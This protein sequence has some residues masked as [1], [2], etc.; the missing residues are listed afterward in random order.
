MDWEAALLRRVLLAM[1]ESIA[2][3]SDAT[4]DFLRPATVAMVWSGTGTGAGLA[5]GGGGMRVGYC[6]V[7]GEKG[8]QRRDGILA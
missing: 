3:G 6:T 4:I 5:R 8:G 1:G 2:G 7:A